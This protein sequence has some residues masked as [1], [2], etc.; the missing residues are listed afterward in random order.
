MAENSNI[1][2]EKFEGL[3]CLKKDA[4]VA[5]YI[6]NHI[7]LGKKIFLKTLDR[8]TVADPAML[9]RFQREAKTLARLEHPNI[10]K[11]YDFGTYEF[12]FYISFEYF[13]SQD[14]RSVI[15]S[16][17][18]S[19]DEKMQVCLQI[20]RGLDY[21]HKHHIIHRDIKPENILL[22]EKQQVKIADFGLA[23]THGDESKTQ[24][25]S[26]VGTPSYMSPEQ[27]RGESLT[28]QTDLF[29]LGILFLE[30]FTGKNPFLG[31][32]AGATL[33][34]VLSRPIDSELFA[35]LPEPLNDIVPKMLAKKQ[36]ER[37]ESA[38]QILAYWKDENEPEKIATATET[39][40]NRRFFSGPWKAAA[41]LFFLLVIVSLVLLSKNNP[42]NTT[43][44]LPIQLTD[45]VQVENQLNDDTLQI[46]ETPEGMDSEKSHQPKVEQAA[47]REPLN[48]PGRLLVQ[49]TPWAV[50]YVDEDSVD[51]TPMEE[52][53]H[54]MPGEHEL[55]L[56]HP[57]FPIYV[58]NFRIE[59]DKETLIAVDLDTLYGFIACD[60][61]PW[62]EV[63]IDEESKGITP[64]PR[65][66]LVTPGSHMLTVKNQQYGAISDTFFVARRDTFYFQL[67]FER[68]VQSGTLN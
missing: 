34:N 32:D 61:Y 3:E 46:D 19:A 48:I 50:V 39:D 17:Q 59:P 58:K 68:V 7:Y 54:I 51:T 63:I 43:E 9:D 22:N 49:C 30:L 13:V 25:T 62:G 15:K 67:N 4:G 18:L 65:P 23:R 20:L 38:A 8:N 11:V 56:S 2:F 57:N 6:A 33:N 14:L 16:G 28:P 66:L 45:S 40:E 52:P 41:G 5:V 36:Q 1:L 55:S 27:I 44:N 37:F 26:I 53:L 47:E 31:D 35:Q 29:S 64:F 21:A 24:Q 42:P 60:I 10:I 12:F